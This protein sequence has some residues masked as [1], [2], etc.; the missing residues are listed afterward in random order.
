METGMKDPEK[1]IILCENLCVLR[2]L[3]GKFRLCCGPKR[4]YTHKK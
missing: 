2:E 3:R 4:V 1:N